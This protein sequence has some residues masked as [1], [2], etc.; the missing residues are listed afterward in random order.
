MNLILLTGMLG[1]SSVLLIRKVT[2]N[3]F[4][5]VFWY[6]IVWSVALTCE[7]IAS[8]GGVLPEIGPLAQDLIVGVHVSVFF[9][10][11]V[12]TYFAVVTKVKTTVVAANLVRV[13]QKFLQIT[14]VF[15]FV[16]GIV[17]LVNRITLIGSVSETILQDIR[18]DYLAD[19]TGLTQIATIAFTPLIFLVAILAFEDYQDGTV[20]LKRMA[21]LYLAANIHGIA[22]GGRIWL[23]TP[24]AFYIF[25]YLI[26]PRTTV[27]TKAAARRLMKPFSRLA[28]VAIALFILLGTFRTS[29]IETIA[30]KMDVAWYEQSSGIML[31]ITYAAVPLAA[32]DLTSQ[33]AALTPPNYGQ[34]L[35]PWFADKLN[36]LGML[37]R[38]VDQ[39]VAI[40]RD[41]IRR[42]DY[43]VASTQCT[44]ICLAVG[45]FGIP[46]TPYVV[47]LLMAA[48]QFVALTWAGRGIFRHAVA[49]TCV[50]AAAMTPQDGWFGIPTNV[51]GLASM[52]VFSWYLSRIATVPIASAQLPKSQL[53]ATSAKP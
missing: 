14:T 45:D 44:V 15:Y 32:I 36:D 39:S 20:R 11:V 47:G 38:Y 48:C 13:P 19:P 51:V 35:F 30:P 22:M 29:D 9:G 5:P 16:L 4:T 37:S 1:I 26:L 40:R 27:Q 18:T 21:L 6:W 8:S 24:I 50:M 25:S 33:Y 3:W 10:F 34:L 23:V 28:V 43:R 17:H 46:A 31:P 42:I 12:A 52:L 53:R 49:V 2:G 41:D 7:A